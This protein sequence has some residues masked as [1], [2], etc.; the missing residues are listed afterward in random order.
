[1]NLQRTFLFIFFS[2]VVSLKQQA[3]ANAPSAF[4]PYFT[5]SDYSMM[6]SPA[7]HSP[8]AFYTIPA[9]IPSPLAVSEV[10]KSAFTP[11]YAQ[12]SRWMP[13]F[14][15]N[16]A[17]AVSEVPHNYLYS[18]YITPGYYYA[19]VANIYSTHPQQEQLNVYHSNMSS[20]IAP[21]QSNDV[22]PETNELSPDLSTE[23]KSIKIENS[24]D[25]TPKY[26]KKAKGSKIR[27]P[28]NAFMIFAKRNR[29]Q[30]FKMHPQCDNRMVSKI[31]SEWWYSLE[32]E[33]KRQFTDL[34]KEIKLEHFRQ[35]PDWKWK[36]SVEKAAN[37]S[38]TLTPSPTHSLKC[39]FP[40]TGNRA[41]S[42]V[43]YGGTNFAVEVNKPIKKL[44]SINH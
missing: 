25:Q 20:Q 36:T 39:E 7:L 9:P 21:T 14:N 2:C 34:A 35:H 22:P 4:S 15:V 32:P 43:A 40:I 12:P 5:P 6:P 41:Q 31:L 27:R 17:P 26:T 44:I 8:H 19:P 33:I 18:N 29:S 11:F 37:V 24:S 13:N 16:S 42:E 10:E 38:D 28:M 1:M 30:V 23:F 3:L